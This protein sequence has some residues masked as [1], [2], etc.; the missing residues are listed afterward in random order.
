[1][2]GQYNT[3]GEVKQMAQYRAD[4]EG[5][6]DRHPG[7]NL[8]Q[9]ANM[10]Y[11]AL[12]VLLANNDVQMVLSPTAIADLPLVEAV[13]GGGYAEIDWPSSFVSVHGLDVKI[14]GAW[15]TLPRGN[16]THRR[17]GAF[18]GE[19]GDYAF[20]GEGQAM[21]IPRSL[22]TVSGATTANGK[23]QLFPVPG[24]GQYVLWGLPEWIDL[25]LDTDLFPGQEEWIDWVI[26][27]LACKLLTRDIGPQTSAQLQMCQVERAAA[28]AR[29]NV[30]TQKLV[31]DEAIQVP[32]RYG[33][34][35]GGYR[36]LP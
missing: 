35:R 10:S 8:G 4:L 31:N 28:W 6:S 21:W 23:I 14:G 34:R 33:S 15:S 16:F 20:A 11:R 30:N 3:L 27:D 26:W 13:S 25:T 18:N 2:A 12:R 9:E 36:M 19:R 32:N 17:L 22:P 5:L 7:A 29:I 24:G 1:M